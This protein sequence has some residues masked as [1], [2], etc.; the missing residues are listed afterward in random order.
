MTADDVGRVPI[1]C[2]GGAAAL[3]KRIA[4]LG[5]AAVLAFDGTQHVAQLQFR[6]Y[7]R[8]CRSPDGLW[9]PLYWGE[10][11]AHAPALPEQ[12]LSIFCYHVGQ[13]DDSERRD[14]RYQ[15]RGLGQT[16]LDHLLAWAADAGFAAVAAKATPAHRAV[17]AFMGGQP[18]AVYR[19]RGFRV[20]ASWIDRQ[21]LDVVHEKGL[22][23]EGTGA[24]AAA[25]VS[26]CVRS[27]AAGADRVGV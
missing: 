2:Q 23:P 21:L 25:R 8:A 16:L 14:A 22:V 3:D 7:D 5:S 4:D 10:F 9:D 20:A 27:L 18:P 1:G 26:L 24:D 11:G 13:R 19:A 12:S 15:G 17:M 6:R